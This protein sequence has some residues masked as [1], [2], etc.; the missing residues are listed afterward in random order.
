LLFETSSFFNNIGKIIGKNPNLA[1]L[2]RDDLIFETDFR[3][4]YSTLLKNKF[5]FDPTT[6]QIKNE[7]IKGG[8]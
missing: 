5:N 3:S 2:D 7:E 6:I 8:F 4:V 1:N